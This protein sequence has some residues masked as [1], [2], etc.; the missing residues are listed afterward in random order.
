MRGRSLSRRSAKSSPPMTD[1]ILDFSE[2]AAYL[3]V[4]NDQLVIER[5]D[6]P[7]ITTPLSEVAA[8]I[9]AHPQ[10]TCSQPVLGR[11]MALGGALVVCDSSHLPIGMMLPLQGH[12]VQTE[13]FAAQASAPLPM[14]K[15]LWKQIV[16]TK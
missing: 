2:S 1:R 9:L 16:Q 3:R 8:L 12:S 4:R 13:R 5:K 7:E 11:L 6:Q 10:A 14:R 15:G